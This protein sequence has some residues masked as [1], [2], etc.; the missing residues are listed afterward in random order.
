MENGLYL[1]EL[2]A[3]IRALRKARK[4]SL[5]ELSEATKINR[6]SL[7][8]LELGYKNSHILTLKVIAESLGVDVRVLLRGLR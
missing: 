4:M 2:G 3:N 8:H 5:K 6:V 7:T 1:K